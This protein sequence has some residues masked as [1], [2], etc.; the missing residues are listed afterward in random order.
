[1]CKSKNVLKRI[2]VCTATLWGLMAM[3]LTAQMYAPIRIGA[4]IA[5]KDEFGVNLVGSSALQASVCDRVEILITASGTNYPPA[6]SGAPTFDN[7]IYSNGV[8]C[9]GNHTA[10]GLVNAGIFSVTLS[11]PLPPAGAKMFVRAF[12]APTLDEAS[13][14][15][16]SKIFTIS[17]DANMVY[18]VAITNMLP[19]DPSDADMD[20]LNN[21]WE[22]SYDTDKEEP[23]SD[24]DGM[25][26]WHEVR[27]GTDPLNA[28]SLFIMAWV[29]EGE[30]DA[31]DALVAWESVAGRRYQVE[32]TEDDLKTHPVY[33]PVGPII[34]ATDAV[35]D[36]TITGGLV[37]DQGH[38]RV[39]L[40]EE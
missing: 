15:G 4:S 3:P 32:Y 14:Y 39:R 26:D 38:Y 8:T 1:M 17:T 31:N 6:T 2:I 11:Q 29:R 7:L 33:T 36:T 30:L 9:I 23:D 27:A 12:N 28:G 35:T 25:G 19:L 16:D 40:I 37:S 22:K 18:D 24:G 13:F 20:G 21:S 34:T 5:I 10:L